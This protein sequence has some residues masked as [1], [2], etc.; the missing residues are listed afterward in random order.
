MNP[1]QTIA[2]ISR[3]D[4]AFQKLSGRPL[5][6]ARGVASQRERSWADFIAAG[7][8]IHELEQVILW[9]KTKIRE[10]QRHESALKF[11]NLVENLVNFD[12]ELATARAEI[13]NAPKIA[14][15][16]ERALRALRPGAGIP[17]SS[18]APPRTKQPKE[19]IEKLIADMRKESQ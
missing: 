6:P 13:R 16:K 14:S 4:S 15:P 11:R 3:L 18:S 9:L 5:T 17:H 12:D 2:E 7:H 10:G 8:N 1:E 19:V